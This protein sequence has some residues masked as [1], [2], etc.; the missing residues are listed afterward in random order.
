VRAA[1]RGAWWVG[2][3]AAGLGLY[4]VLEG[5]WPAA[6]ACFAVGA[7][8]LWF[9][10]VWA[11]PWSSTAYVRRLG[12]AW[13]DWA[14]GA[15]WAYDAYSRRRSRLVAR[16]EHLSPPPELAA[17]HARLIALLGDTERLVS[18][19]ST[20]FAERARRAGRGTPW[21]PDGGPRVPRG[22][23]NTRSGPRWHGG[24]PGGLRGPA[25]C[26]RPGRGLG[27]ARRRGA[28][29]VAERAIMTDGE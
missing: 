18:D 26:E 7:A 28:E 20:P 27:A 13:T 17:E 6:V 8:L 3:A 9:S 15:Q 5:I 19:E 4:L 22:G 23:W 21:L 11:P 25:A 1:V 2:V 29:A 24:A 16:V 14:T 12:Y 10:G